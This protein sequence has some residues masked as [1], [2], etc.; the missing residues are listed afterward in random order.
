MSTLLI[1]QVFNFDNMFALLQFDILI[2][3]CVRYKEINNLPFSKQ[4]PPEQVPVLF[5]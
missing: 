2:S 5:I 4:K 3:I 1:N